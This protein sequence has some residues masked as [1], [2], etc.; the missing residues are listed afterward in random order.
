MER[1]LDVKNLTMDFGGLRAVEAVDLQL[2]RLL[3]VIESL[4]GAMIVTA[5]HGNADCMF[6]IDKKTGEPARDARGRIKAKT[7]HTLNSVPL[8]VFAP[9]LAATMK[10]T[11]P[12]AGLSNLAATILHLMGFEAPEDY[13]PSVLDS[14]I[15]S[16]RDGS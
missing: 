3:P 4:G 11:L 10:S 9:G 1:I 14:V 6:E 2:A 13:Q 5:D 16:K 12:D 15:E 8:H 7:S